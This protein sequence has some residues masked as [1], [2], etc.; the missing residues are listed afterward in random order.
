[1]NFATKPS[2]QIGVEIQDASGQPVD[3]FHLAACAQLRGDE[4]EQPVTW[5]SDAKLTDLVGKP[6]RLRFVLISADLFSIRFRD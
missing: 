4:I 6:I 1:M 5:Q 2:G 3:G